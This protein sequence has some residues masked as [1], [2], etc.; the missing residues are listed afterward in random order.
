MTSTVPAV[1]VPVRLGQFIRLPFPLLSVTVK[2]RHRPPGQGWASRPEAS[3]ARDAQG[4]MP[5]SPF[6]GTPGQRRARPT[7][8]DPGPLVI[9]AV[10]TG[11][12]AVMDPAWGPRP[13]ETP[14][15]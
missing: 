2:L 4:G 15:Q 9:S 12:A 13:K 6:R 3:T 5:Q 11:P 1:S 7:E 14:R 10:V 8:H